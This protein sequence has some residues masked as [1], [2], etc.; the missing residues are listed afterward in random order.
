[1]IQLCTQ[2]VNVV[3]VLIGVQATFLPLGIRVVA[4]LVG[5]IL[6]FISKSTRSA[7]PKTIGEPYDKGT[8]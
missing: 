6:A 4:S 3:A 1:M 5:A 7:A 2:K 8:R